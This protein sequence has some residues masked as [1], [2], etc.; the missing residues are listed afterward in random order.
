MYG[1]Y[2][3]DPRAAAEAARGRP[4]ERETTPV[5]F[6]E[7][8]AASKLPEAMSPGIGTMSVANSIQ[9]CLLCAVAVQGK[10]F[11]GGVEAPLITKDDLVQYCSQW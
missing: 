5:K 2:G 9:R 3:Y 11:I 6:T 7:V 4:P 8:C 1:M 10:L